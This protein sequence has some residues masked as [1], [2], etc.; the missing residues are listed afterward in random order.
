VVAAQGFG[1]PLLR[2]WPCKAVRI[3]R[4]R[5][6]HLESLAS[7]A[8]SQFTPDVSTATAASFRACGRP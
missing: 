7:E 2:G 4:A 1:A 5:D 3:D 8:L 6:R